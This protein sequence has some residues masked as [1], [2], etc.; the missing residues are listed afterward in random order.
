MTIQ[1]DPSILAAALKLPQDQWDKLLKAED[2]TFKPQAE[3][4]AAIT[5]QITAYASGRYTEGMKTGEGRGTKTGESKLI[6]KLKEKF[7]ID[8][9]DDVDVLIDQYIEKLKTNTKIDPK[10]VRD[11][12]EYKAAIAAEKKALEDLKK[13]YD[14]YKAGIEQKET[15][16]LVM[17]QFEPLFEGFALPDGDFGAKQKELIIS[18]A[19]QGKKFSIEN[20]KPILLNDDNSILKDALGHPVEFESYGKQLI[21]T[22]VPAKVGD[23][24]QSPQGTPGGTPPAGF[25]QKGDKKWQLPKT[26]AEMESI[27]DTISD[28]TERIEY[29]EAS[30]KSIQ[31]ASAAT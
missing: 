8:D 1:I 26:F 24:R 30:E 27:A 23:T 19:L 14:G 17:K 16:S 22:Y 9:I 20:G 3:I 28:A 11:S 29:L 18:A 12:A 2:G 6:A 5:S 7:E 10:S 21:G 15:L 31:A 4:E 25:F 13:E